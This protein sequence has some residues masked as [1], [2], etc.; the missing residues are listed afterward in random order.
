[1][2]MMSTY[3]YDVVDSEQFKTA[4]LNLSLKNNIDPMES[5]S[6]NI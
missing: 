3:M 1:M 5:L 4:A 6:D 2:I